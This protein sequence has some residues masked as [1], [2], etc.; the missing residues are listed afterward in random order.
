MEDAIK[1]HLSSKSNDLKCC[2]LTFEEQLLFL[3]IT[4]KN[5]KSVP[6]IIFKEKTFML[7][8]LDITLSNFKVFI[9][10]FEG[11]LQDQQILLNHAVAKYNTNIRQLA[12]TLDILYE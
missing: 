2:L 8:K 12:D 4:D 7:L 1:K 10:K 5:D 6:T 9:E 11:Q 3:Q